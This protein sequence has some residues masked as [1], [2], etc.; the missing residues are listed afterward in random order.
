M[1]S[2]ETGPTIVA[3]VSRLQDLLGIFMRDGFGTMEG[4]RAANALDIG[5]ARLKS[6]IETTIA[7]GTPGVM[8]EVD[9]AFYDLTVKERDTARALLVVA[10][11]RVETL[12]TALLSVP[13]AEEV[14]R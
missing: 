4:A 9:R 2:P 10:E 11:Q 7:A 8:H 5:L 14:S 1:T 6:Q 3:E 12:T 13:T